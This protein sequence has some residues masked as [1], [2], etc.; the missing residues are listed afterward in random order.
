MDKSPSERPHKIIR[1]TPEQRAKMREAEQARK[2]EESR[3]NGEEITTLRSMGDPFSVLA[4]WQKEEYSH[5]GANAKIAHKL[6][7][8]HNSSKLRTKPDKIPTMKKVAQKN[9]EKSA[10]ENTYH[11]KGLEAIFVAAAGGEWLR[12]PEGY[13]VSAY[14]SSEYDDTCG[15]RIDAVVT[16]QSRDETMLFGVDLY[17]EDSKEKQGLSSKEESDK[18]WHRVKKILQSNNDRHFAGPI[19]FSKI[20]TAPHIKDESSLVAGN[21]IIDEKTKEGNPDTSYMLPRFV[22]GVDRDEIDT[23]LKTFKGGDYTLGE[24]RN[25]KGKKVFAPFEHYT[26]L[27]ELID[28]S[29]LFA[30]VQ[31][32]SDKEK[33]AD[34][35]ELLRKLEATFKEMRANLY[36]AMFTGSLSMTKE[37]QKET[38]EAVLAD[39][40]PNDDKYDA[41]AK[42]INKYKKDRVFTVLTGITGSLKRYNPSQIADI[43]AECKKREHKDSYRALARAAIKASDVT[44]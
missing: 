4:I 16:I 30:K 21:A 5:D 41:M 32:E 25:S 27:Q 14:S 40:Y 11:A 9:F 17:S 18:E 12:S 36:E 7:S 31:E 1:Q 10:G 2:A 19:G 15:N 37:Q 26:I 35:I 8:F 6:A 43:K 24:Y 22:V 13:Q 42:L 33:N 20:N 38:L 44:S 29:Q 3:K 28:Q 34:T 39:R 23:M